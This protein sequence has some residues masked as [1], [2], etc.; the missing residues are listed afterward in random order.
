[1]EKEQELLKIAEEISKC[2]VC[3]KDK[4]GLPVPGEGNPN[5][6]IMFIG[7]AP[8]IEE[9]KT[10]KPFIGRAGKF[11]D[12]LFALIK[13]ERKN[14]FITSPLKYYPGR[15]SIKNLEIEH[16]KIHL[17]KQIEIIQP[18]L[19]VLLGNVAIKATLGRN[20]ELLKI[21]GK[22][23][24]KDSI[25]YF[26]TFHPAAGMRFP[27]V[28]KLIKGDFIKLKKIINKIL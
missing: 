24:E 15:R 1:M 20:Y 17:Q 19:I 25:F 9:S 23:I 6:K 2:T 14:V 11:L 3:K 22:L 13:I 16:G 8:G 18:K 4:F 26:P 28:K 5:A 21:H 27:K 12:K 7:E 10:G